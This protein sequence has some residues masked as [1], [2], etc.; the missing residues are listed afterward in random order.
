[1]SRKH[2]IVSLCFLYLAL[3]ILYIANPIR[4]VTPPPAGDLSAFTRELDVQIPR[5]MRESRVPGTSIALIQSGKLVWT[6]G[7]GFANIETREV[8]TAETLFQGSSISKTVTAWGVMKLVEE[9]KLNLDSP[10]ET[11][12]RRWHLPPSSFDSNKVTIR[13]LLSHTSGLAPVDYLGYPPD[14]PIPSLEESLTNGPPALVGRMKDFP[15]T[16]DSGAV[17]LVTTPGQAFRYSDGN[18]LLLQLIIEEV[19]G[20]PFAV[21][22]QREVLSPLGMTNSSFARTPELISRTAVPYDVYEK[23]LPDYAFTELAPAG[24][25]TTTS[26]LTRLLISGLRGANGEL[27]GDSIISSDSIHLMISPA[28]SIS[29]FHGWLNGSAY[30][31]GYYIDPQPDG[32]NLLSQSGG[33]LGWSC[34]FAVFPSTGDA[35]IIMDNSSVGQEVF[36]RALTSWTDWLGRDETPIAHAILMGRRAFQAFSFSLLL[37]AT[38]LFARLF[39]RIRSGVLRFRFPPLASHQAMGFGLCA[40]AL[41]WYWIFGHPWMLINIPS[42]PTAMLYGVNLLCLS[43]FLNLS[44]VQII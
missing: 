31:F 20:E 22:M 33:D 19:T 17:R 11:Y 3:T 35:I 2:L 32:E 21:Y 15:G 36:A 44:F 40:I 12:L 26:D 25:Y 24:L 28:V 14:Q 38:I 5:V 27:V 39:I 16:R 9:G 43:I 30:G 18:Y 23:P 4:L 8:V 1:M 37:V 42:Q 10:A 6:R 41:V 13:R 29:G 34:D 7:Y